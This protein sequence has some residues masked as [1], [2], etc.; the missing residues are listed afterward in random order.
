MNM[1]SMMSKEAF[2]AYL[3]MVVEKA[4]KEG[5]FYERAKEKFNGDVITMEEAIENAKRNILGD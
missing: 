1:M 5:M 2:K 3:D 4:F